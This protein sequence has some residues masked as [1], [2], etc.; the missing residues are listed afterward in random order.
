MNVTPNNYIRKG[1]AALLA[2]LILTGGALAGCGSSADSEQ[3]GA[4]A[5][6]AASGQTSGTTVN[7]GREATGNDAASAA[8]GAEHSEAAYPLTVT[9]EL[10]HEMTIPAKPVR[11]FA[12]M[13]ED[14]MVA[15]GIQPAMQWSNGVEP[16]LYLQDRLSGVPE[17]SFAS[18][19]PSAEAVL[20][21]T[22][23]LIVLHNK[24]YAEN[25][26]YEQ[27]AKIAPTYVF[28]SASDDLRSSIATLGKLLGVPDKAE[29]AATRYAEQVASAK[30]KLAGIAEGKKAAI[31]R[32]NAKGM[33]FLSGDTYSGAVLAQDL[34]FGQSELVKGG[35]FE[36]S[37][38]ILPQL[39]ADYIFLVNDGHLGDAALADLKASG[40][41][42]N[43]PAVKNGSVYETSSGYWLSGG[44]IAQGKVI[45]DVLGFLAP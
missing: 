29:E 22:P 31:I 32:F 7:A 13:M 1:R 33:F 30:E 28:E 5:S 12:P 18:G 6:N 14:S 37:L 16:Q 26:V 23:D 39:E 15:L 42:Q 17:M 8:Q 44:Y 43:V 2:A 41:W 21:Q 38:E 24:F 27:Y 34:G 10:G 3:A 25:G 20:A 36:V 4:P 11:V 19:P 35:A 45:D 9:D 40:I